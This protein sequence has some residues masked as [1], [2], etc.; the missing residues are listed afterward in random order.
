MEVIRIAQKRG[1]ARLE[2]PEDVDSYVT[3]LMYQPDY[4][5]YA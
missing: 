1:L 3:S 5:T 2:I 4:P